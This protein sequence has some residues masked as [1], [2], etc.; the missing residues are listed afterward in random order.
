MPSRLRRRLTA[1]LVAALAALLLSSGS[2]AAST[3]D[4]ST[5]DPATPAPE[6]PGVRTEQ[7]RIAVP[8]GP[9]A[10]APIE[11]DSTL[12]LP[13]TSPAPAVLVAHGFGGSKASVDTDA[14]DLAARGFVVLAWS[15]RGFGASGGQIALNSPDYEVADGRALVDWL[16][17]RPEVVQDGPGDPRVGITGGSYGGALSLLLAGYDRRV[18]ALAPVITWNDLGQALFPN[19]AAATPPPVDTPAHGAFAPDGVFKSGWAGI[20]FSAGLGP[21]QTGPDSGDAEDTS[22]GGL[23]GATGGLGAAGSGAATDPAAGPA[24]PTPPG[25]G[26]ATCGRFVPAVCTAYT[27]SATTGRISPGTAEL[28]RRSSPASVTD[29]ITAPTLLV[30][31]E[32]D[33]L[34]GLDQADANA[35]QI[36]ATGAPVKVAWFAGGH[37]GGRIGQGVRDEIGDW[38]SWHL[39]RDGALA[40]RGDDPG[41]GFGYAVESGIRTLQPHPDRP[42]RRGHR[43]PRPPRRFRTGHADHCAAG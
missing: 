10:P 43:L 40:E 27:E 11:L 29:R 22:G 1:V 14:R 36:A 8:G 41:T 12:Y 26:P 4:P 33:T 35:R 37:D 38:F 42:H 21:A 31:G 17:T 7:Q 30:Q 9:G 19:A 13:D 20:F 28:L 25:A 3:P 15:A 32:Q 24:A 2:A 18:D 6:T 16:A 23:A 39:G 34:F 5:S